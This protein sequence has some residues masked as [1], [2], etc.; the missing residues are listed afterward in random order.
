MDYVGLELTSRR[1][2]SISLLSV[3]NCATAE[4]I[5]YRNNNNLNNNFQRKLVPVPDKPLLLKWNNP[6]QRS[7]VRGRG[8]CIGHDLPITVNDR[9]HHFA[10]ILF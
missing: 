3:T 10:R 9:F 8:R 4:C 1:S 5:K 7:L 2:A 6:I